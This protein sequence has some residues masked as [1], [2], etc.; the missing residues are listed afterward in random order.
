MTMRVG[1]IGDPVVHSLSPVMHNAALAVLGL[2]GTYE[3]WQTPESELAERV[4]GLRRS[5]TLGANVTVPHKQAVLH[6]CDEV[7]E[8]ARRIGA[9]NTIV[10]RGGHLHGDN[11]DA[12]GFMRA[13][14]GLPRASGV[15]S[16]L[17]L[18]AGGAA[19]AVAVALGTAGIDSI[20]IANRTPDRA[21]HLAS[22]LGDAGL[23]GVRTIAWSDLAAALSGTTLLINATSIGWHHDET[24][25]P[26]SY[27]DHL[28]AYTCVFDLTYR[29]TALIRAARHR[30]IVVSDGLD[31]LIYQGARALELWTGRTPP[32]EAMREAV[33]AEQRHRG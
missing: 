31:M 32:V 3:L 13:L 24:P 7:S 23:T 11:T 10:T 21:R 1:L 27:L 14:D 20:S 6:L 16:A 18:G 33:L 29:D 15:Q 9:V 19:R 8:R 4:E 12:Y 22:A 26:V 5:D 28:P 2:D 25:I 30:G 17:I